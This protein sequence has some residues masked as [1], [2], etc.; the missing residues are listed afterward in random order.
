MLYFDQA[1]SY[2]APRLRVQFST[3]AAGKKAEI[4]EIRLR[5]D[6]PL[7]LILGQRSVFLKPNGQL[8]GRPEEG[9]IYTREEDL[10][11]TF[12]CGCGYS[13]HSCEQQ[14]LAGFLTLRGGHR[15]GLCGTAVYSGGILTGVRD[16]SSL[17]IRIARE[18]PKVASK[19]LQRFYSGKSL[20]SVLICGE[21]LSGKTTLLRDIVYHLSI[22]FSGVCHKVA[23]VDE[24]G[25]LGGTYEGKAQLALGPCTDVLNGYPKGKGM[26]IALRTLSPD[27]IVCD[28][29]G[30]SDEADAILQSANAGVSILATAHTRDLSSLL[31]RVQ[32]RRLIEEQV[33]DYYVQLTGQEH[34][35]KIHQIL[36]AGE[37]YAQMER[38][39]TAVFRLQHAGLDSVGKAQTTGGTLTA[40][41]TDDRSQ[42]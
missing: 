25:E 29:I 3:I 24:R 28:E 36:S 37:L 42:Y 26:N 18:H 12:Q 27:L 34:P 21:P 32:I 14:V 9:V 38:N 7:S 4:R 15:M 13:V 31:Y 11:E 1:I 10:Q 30:E 8:V 33:F 39:L 17:N 19:L 35:G 22:G 41:R 16:I 6:Q 5:C 40:F 20:P 2:I 23:V